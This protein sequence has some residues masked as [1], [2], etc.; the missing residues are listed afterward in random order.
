MK[1]ILLIALAIVLFL[2]AVVFAAYPAISNYVNDKYQSKIRTEYEEEVRELDNSALVKIKEQAAAYNESLSPVQFDKAGIRDAEQGYHDLLDPSNS[3]IMGYVIIPKININL[4]IYH[5]TAESVLEEGVG[6]LI[7]SS[8]PV[9]GESCHSVLTGHSG[10]AEK[11]LFSDLDQ[12]EVGDRFYLKVLGEYLAYEVTAINTVLPHETEL[13]ELVH[14]EDLCTL[15]TC[16]PFAVNTHRLLIRG[17]RVEYQNDLEVKQTPDNLTQNEPSSPTKSTW[18]EQYIAGLKYGALFAG[19]A[20][21]VF[22]V[23]V[24]LRRRRR[25]KT[26]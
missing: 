11:K 4:P 6:H 3:G 25:R 2:S 23:I 19:A 15:V 5:G 7:G 18:K 21:L 10:V 12:L 26:T 24:F 14:G 22:L 17:S 9:G 1:R 8:L 20:I 13:L 16:T